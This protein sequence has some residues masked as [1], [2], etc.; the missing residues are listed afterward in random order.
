MSEWSAFG[1]AG[2]ISK[3]G[4]TEKEKNLTASLSDT[5]LIS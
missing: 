1:G 3:I 2:H 4:K 5:F